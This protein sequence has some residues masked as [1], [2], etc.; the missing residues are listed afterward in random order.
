VRRRWWCM[1]M[2]SSWLGRNGLEAIWLELKLYWIS[3]PMQ[4]YGTSFQVSAFIFSL[5]LLSMLSIVSAQR[6][7]WLYRPHDAPRWVIEPCRWLLLEREMHIRRLF[8][9][10]HRCCSSAATWRRHCSSHRTPH[11][12]V[13]LCDRL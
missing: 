12:S 6:Q 13:Q 3:P 8:V 1:T 9:L 10:R 11:H 4:H 5:K 7:C 2:V